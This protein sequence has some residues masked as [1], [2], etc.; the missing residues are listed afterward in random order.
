MAN[1]IQKS[2]GSYSEEPIP[3][4][5]ETDQIFFSFSYFNKRYPDEST[6]RI[7]LKVIIRAYSFSIVLSIG[8]HDP[9]PKNSL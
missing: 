6:V 4:K 5:L 9:Y 8:K 1:L 3:L 2:Y 7:Y